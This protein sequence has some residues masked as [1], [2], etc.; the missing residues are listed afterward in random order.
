VVRLT[1]H[2]CLALVV[3]PGSISRHNEAIVK[4]AN[5]CRVRATQITSDVNRRCYLSL[6]FLL[7]DSAQVW[8]SSK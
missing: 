2:E 8:K 6:M 5:G 1:K 4:Q 3:R 7:K